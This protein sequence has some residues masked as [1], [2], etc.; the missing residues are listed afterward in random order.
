[1][2]VGQ[3]TDVVTMEEL[4]GWSAFFALQNEEAEK[5]RDATQKVRASRAQKR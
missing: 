5:Q 4:I 2:T 3:L 1:M